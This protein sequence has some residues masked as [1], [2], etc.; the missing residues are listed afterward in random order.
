MGYTTEF[1]GQIKINPPLNSDE[2][3]YLKKFNDTRRMMRKNGPYFVDGSGMMGQGEDKDIIE[4]NSPP[5]GQPGLWCQWT[6]TEDGTAIEW[7]GGE[8]F[9]AS[10]EWMEYI[11]KHFIGSNPIAPTK[12]T[13]LQFLKPH[14]LN[15]VIEAQ[16]EDD[17]DH[18]F[19]VVED[20]EVFSFTEEEYE[21]HKITKFKDHVEEILPH[22]AKENNQTKI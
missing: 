21:A 5:E 19:L 14:T 13:T 16:G 7:D 20:N 6:P 15:G 2:I 11:I 22:K 3:N 18:W 4:Y 17:E 12:E 1:E 8:K 9:Y 10:E